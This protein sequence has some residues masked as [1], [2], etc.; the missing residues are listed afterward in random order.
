MDPVPQSSFIPRQAG[1]MVAEPPRKRRGRFNVLS[2]FAMIFFFG[3]I[4]LAMGV[5]FL[6]RNQEHTLTA[7]KDELAGKRSEFKQDS[8]D[9]IRELDTRIRTAEYL[10]DSHMSPSRLFDVLERTTQ[11]HIQYTT[12]D[13][14]RRPSGSV[15]VSMIGIAPHFNTVSRQAQRYAD[16]VKENRF[17]RVIFSNLNKP[18]P[19]HV[20]FKV[21]MDIAK[22]QISYNAP[23]NSVSD[24]IQNAAVDTSTQAGDAPR[25]AS[26]SSPVASTTVKATPP[27]K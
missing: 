24:I 3:S 15:S 1:N 13:L 19:D 16:E 2:F 18:A 27:K 14:N 21:D 12:F 7:K 20:S 17:A 8:I 10:M 6:E 22:D 26:T 9:S 4:I 23:D 11:E 25:V 5:W